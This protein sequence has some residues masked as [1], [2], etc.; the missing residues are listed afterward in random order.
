MGGASTSG[1]PQ[2]VANG[3]AAAASKRKRK[4][5][6]M[7]SLLE[8]VTA[9]VSIQLHPSSLLDV[10][11][12]IRE[13]LN[14]LLLRFNEQ[15]DGV[16]LAYRDV[17]QVGRTAAVSPYFP[18]CK[19][20]VEVRFT[21][22]RLGVGSYVEGR[23]TEVTDTFIG[24]LL[25]E[26]VNAV[27][28]VGDVKGWTYSLYDHRWK[29]VKDAGHGIGCGDLVRV[30]L[31]GLEQHGG[32]SVTV[33]ASLGKGCGN[34]AVIGCAGADGAADGDG[35]GVGKRKAKRAKNSSKK[36]DKKEDKKDKRDKEKRR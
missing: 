8:D 32:G 21:L 19:V 36:K 10:S 24:L 7:Q 9:N 17:R 35:D 11:L 12:G 27:V 22:L 2:H 6:G 25:Y 23:V 28:L 4:S 29:G 18:M 14:N 16:P 3:A 13:H 33:R 1:L 15:L 34:V 20:N 31:A 30:K 5:S 26:V